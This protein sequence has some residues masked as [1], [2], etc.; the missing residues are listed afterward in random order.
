M[1]GTGSGF[2]NINSLADWNVSKVTSMRNMFAERT[3]NQPLNNWNVSKVTSMRNMFADART[4]NQ[5]LNNWNVSNVK[6][7]QEMFTGSHGRISIFNQDISD[8]DV[9]S[10]TTMRSMFRGG[11]TI[12]NQPLNNWNVSSL[13][14]AGQMFEDNSV[15]NQPLN[16]WNVSKV[17]RMVEMFYKATAFNQDISNW[18]IINVND[19]HSFGK[20]SPTSMSNE[21]ININDTNQ[22]NYFKYKFDDSTLQSAI[23]LHYDTETIQATFGNNYWGA[24]TRNG[25]IQL[26]KG[27]TYIFDWSNVDHSYAGGPFKIYTTNPSG[28]L[29][30]NVIIDT[31]ARNNY[32]YCNRNYSYSTKIWRWWMGF[33]TK[34]YGYYY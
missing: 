3:F 27:K 29:T 11:S 30:E 22:W 12:F 17:T 28:V 26:Y 8:W 32:T 5:P 6:D 25:P 31:N 16:N 2:N 9:S 24:P 10:V 21:F 33:A 23:D 4:F 15:F 18:D 20:T 7:M 34:W 14:D 19:F 13:K 1:F